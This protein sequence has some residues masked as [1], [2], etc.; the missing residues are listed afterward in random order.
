MGER[1]VEESLLRLKEKMPVNRELKE[2]LRSEFLNRRKRRRRRA[3]IGG[4]A[5]AAAAMLLVFQ[6]PFPGGGGGGVPAIEAASLA[7]MNQVSFV[8]IGT[9]SPKGVSEHGGTV[10]LPI[11]G[12]GVYAYDASGFHPV[13][14]REAEIVR[15]SPSGEKLLVANSGVIGVYDMN[16]GSFSEVAAGEQPAW[17]DEETILYVQDGFVYEAGVAEDGEPQLVAEGTHPAYAA[18]SGAVLLE[19]DGQIVKRLGGEE[20]VLDEGRF[21]AVSPD[22]AY[23]AYVKG[24]PEAEQVWVAD[25]S[26]RT[27]RAVTSNAFGY[28]Y[29]EPSWSSDSESLYVWKREGASPTPSRLMRIDFTDA[30]LGAV[31]TVKAFNQAVI[32]RD[33]D[34]AR[35]WLA[36]EHEFAVL[37]NPIQIGYAVRGTGM[38][39]S[40]EYVDVEEYWSYTADAYYTI[41][42]V[43]YYVVRQEDGGYLIDEMKREVQLTVRSGSDGS[44]IEQVFGGGERE[45]LF[46]RADIPQELLPEG[47]YRFAALAYV[48][49]TGEVIFAVQAFDPASVTVLSFDLEQRTFRSLGQISRMGELGNVGVMK[50][51]VSPDGT[52]AALDLF[53]DDDLAF[54]SR[55]MVLDLHMQEPFWVEELLEDTAV[56]S[57]HSYY[58][59]EGLLHFTLASGG[60]TLYYVWDAETKQIGRP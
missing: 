18:E 42:H 5:A 51:I 43:R 28:H 2:R 13:T 53:S 1:Q 22:G 35:G 3:W 30:E 52:Y 23:A 4:W 47:E 24:G 50:M 16:S 55:M 12:Q 60:E 21:P 20:T 14:E 44:Q 15:V 37:S 19:R 17:K 45:V 8:K 9:G 7:I 59:E 26:G 6:I 46:T 58:W 38:E 56:S 54:G 33:L 29:A 49:S 34:A 11:D 25:V 32:R 40:R 31:E 39:G 10:Y 48:E 41:E 57:I 36:H 27:K